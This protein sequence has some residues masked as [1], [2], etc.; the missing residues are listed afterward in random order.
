MGLELSASRK[1]GSWWFGSGRRGGASITSRRPSRRR[2]GKPASSGR[3]DNEVVP[4]LAE[5]TGHCIAF[6]E[7]DPGTNEC[8]F[9]L[10]DKARHK[11]VYVRGAHNIP[12][13]E[14]A[15]GLLEDY[16]WPLNET[17]A[18]RTCRCTAC[19]WRQWRQGLVRNERRLAGTPALVAAPLLPYTG[20]YSILRVIVDVSI[21][22]VHHSYAGRIY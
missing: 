9:E 11:V 17:E 16:G 2:A 19:R 7:R 5:S 20:R 18:T 14:D 4:L 8:W 6:F 15:A 21:L 10:R 1:G 3:H 22:E 13:P 12:A